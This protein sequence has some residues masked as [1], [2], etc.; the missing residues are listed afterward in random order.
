MG[1]TRLRA[2]RDGVW[3]GSERPIGGF[4]DQLTLYFGYRRTVDRGRGGQSD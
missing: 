4:P 3:W 1:Q 2:G